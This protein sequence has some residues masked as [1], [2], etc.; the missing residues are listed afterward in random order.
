MVH[1]K[2]VSRQQKPNFSS[3]QNCRTKL[4]ANQF[5]EGLGS[6]V[7]GPR[8]VNAII[9]KLQRCMSSTTGAVMSLGDGED[10]AVVTLSGLKPLVSIRL[11]T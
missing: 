1:A 2:Q 6:L 9:Q 5:R 4:A 8:A 3:Q 7:K 11:S 10:D